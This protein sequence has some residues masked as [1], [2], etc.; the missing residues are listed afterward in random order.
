MLTA[1]RQEEALMVQRP[2]GHRVG[3]D[4]QARMRMQGNLTWMVAAGPVMAAVGDQGCARFQKS[5]GPGA[6]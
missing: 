6:T 5:C 1:A 4:G 3:W 2:Q